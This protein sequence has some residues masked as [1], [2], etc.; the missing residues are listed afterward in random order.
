MSEMQNRNFAE[1]AEQKLGG[2][3][4]SE[5]NMTMGRPNLKLEREASKHAILNQ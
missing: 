5:V 3:M 1:D 2:S 4:G